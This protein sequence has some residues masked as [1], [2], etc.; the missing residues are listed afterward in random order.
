MSPGCRDLP[1]NAAAESYVIWIADA[2]RQG[3]G[4]RLSLD[5]NQT[6]TLNG[7]TYHNAGGGLF[8]GGAHGVFGDVLIDVDGVV[9]ALAFHMEGC[10]V[11][12]ASDLWTLT[13]AVTRKNPL[14]PASAAESVE[15]RYVVRH[16]GSGA[17]GFYTFDAEGA[18]EGCASGVDLL[19]VVLRD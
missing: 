19:Q 8:G 15:R 6:V 5:L 7:H 14:S 9:S 12:V 18:P 13:A 3:G 2:T 4:D 11:S 17:T 16:S 10:A 1:Y